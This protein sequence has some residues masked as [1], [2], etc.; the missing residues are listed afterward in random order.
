[1]RHTDEQVAAL[2]AL[3]VLDTKLDADQAARLLAP[4]ALWQQWIDGRSSTALDGPDSYRVFIG[5]MCVFAD[6]S[7]RHCAARD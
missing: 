1:M 6:A 5:Q 7:A 4:G 2:G 3:L